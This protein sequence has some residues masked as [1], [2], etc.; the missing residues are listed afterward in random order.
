MDFLL[1]LCVL[2]GL[3]SGLRWNHCCGGTCGNPGIEMIPRVRVV[4]NCLTHRVY[5]ENLKDPLI[6]GLTYVDSIWV[7]VW[8]NETEIAFKY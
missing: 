3:H 5:A 2:G 6:T 8:F 7:N 4:M 1:N